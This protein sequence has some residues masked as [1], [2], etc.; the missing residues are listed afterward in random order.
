MASEKGYATPARYKAAVRLVE[1]LAKRVVKAGGH[2]PP[3][4]DQD[5]LSLPEVTGSNARTYTSA[6]V[7]IEGTSEL[8]TTVRGCMLFSSG[9]IKQLSLTQR[10]I[11]FVNGDIDSLTSTSESIIIC[12]G[13]IKRCLST[14]AGCVI[15]CNGVIE[16][17]STAQ[18]S[19]VFVRGELRSWTHPTNNVIEVQKL[20]R[21]TISQGNVY[22]NRDSVQ[23]S[24]SM[25]DR[26]TKFTPSVLDMFRFFDPARAGLEF[27]MADGDARVEKLT[28][29]KP[30]AR[31]GLQKGDL[32]LA[33]NRH[34]YLTADDF[35][36]LLR[37]RVIAGSAQLKVQRGDRVLQV[38]VQFA[39]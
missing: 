35:T 27:T 13:T 37:R 3:V 4:L 34:K 6:R 1:A 14:R 17:M 23:A 36:R 11:L 15:F 16:S 26:F 24:S 21:C 9:S 29:G 33:I 20:G 22:L 7:R 8:L 2:K 19:A 32:I 5:F 25:N 28:E 10:S 12:N 31:A 18:N 38:S 30:F 39:P